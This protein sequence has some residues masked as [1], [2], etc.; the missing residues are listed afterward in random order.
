MNGQTLPPQHGYPLRLVVPGWYR[1]GA[2]QW[3]A[4]DRGDRHDS[5]DSRNAVAYRLRRRED[6]EQATDQPDRAPAGL[7][8]RRGIPTS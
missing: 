1:H 3:A 8:I 6:G 7:L 5:P 2:C 4:L